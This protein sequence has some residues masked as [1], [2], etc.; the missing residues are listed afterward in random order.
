M[1]IQH[2][3]VM[4]HYRLEMGLAKVHW[5]NAQFA[6][7]GIWFLMCELLATHRTSESPLH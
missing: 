1:I 7:Q 5:Y 4:L 6:N 3:F 2:Q